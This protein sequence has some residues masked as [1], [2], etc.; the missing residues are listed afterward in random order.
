MVNVGDSI[1]NGNTA[2]IYLLPIKTTFYTS[3]PLVKKMYVKAEGDI[4]DPTNYNIYVHY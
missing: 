1:V 4:P 3:Y 2:D